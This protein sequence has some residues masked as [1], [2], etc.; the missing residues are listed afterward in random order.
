MFCRLFLEK[1]RSHPDLGTV[2]TADKAVN[3]QKLREVFPI[4]EDLKNRLLE[5]YKKEYQRHLRDKVSID[6]KEK[7]INVLSIRLL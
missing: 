1:I 4:A 3:N 2:P 6:F 7:C 5:Q